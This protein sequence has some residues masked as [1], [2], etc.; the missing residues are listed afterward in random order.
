MLSNIPE[1]YQDLLRDETRALVFLGTTMPDGSPQVTPVWFNTDGD[2]IL[3]NSAAGRVK[4]RNMRV[5]PQV[6]L[7][8]GDPNNAYRYIQIRGRVVEVTTTNARQH[9]NQLAQKYTGKDF[10]TS[11]NPDEQRVIYKIKPEKLDLHS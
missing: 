3:I 11:P 10:Y 9:I 4:D 5:R 1:E 6:A 8:I 2:F 7:A